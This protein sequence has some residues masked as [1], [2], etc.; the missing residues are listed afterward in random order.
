MWRFRQRRVWVP[1][2]IFG[3]IAVLLIVVGIIG[4]F[5]TVPQDERIAVRPSV[6]P[7]VSSVDDPEKVE[8]PVLVNL[9]STDDAHKMALAASQVALSPDTARFDLTDYEKVFAAS[10]P[11]APEFSSGSETMT[12]GQ[13]GQYVMKVALSRDPWDDRVGVKATDEFKPQKATTI[14]SQGFTTLLF[15]ESD[16]GEFRKWLDAQPITV[17]K[18]EGALGRQW[19]SA[20]G[21]R[22]EKDMGQVQTA[23]GMVC[24]DQCRVIAVLPPGKVEGQ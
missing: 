5:S 12:Q 20:D 7:T 8:H 21:Q 10:T 1:V 11:Q 23:V 22:L 4:R 17:V 6:E 24:N 9:P 18:V 16:G 14:D 3:T 13:W 15:G 19:T 2:A